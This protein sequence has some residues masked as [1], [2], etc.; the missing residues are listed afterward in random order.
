MDQLTRVK[1]AVAAAEYGGGNSRVS[2]LARRSGI[3]CL[4]DIFESLSAGD[5]DHVNAR[6]TALVSKGVSAALLG[7]TE[8]PQSLLAI[9]GSPPFL[10][11]MG[12]DALLSCPG[13]GVCGSRDVSSEGLRAAKACGE[14]ASQ[15]GFTVISGYARGVDITTHTSALSSGGTTVLVLPEGIE[16]FRVRRGDF[17]EVWDP[18]RTLVISQFAPGRPWSAGNA[19]AR[20]RVIIGL[21]LALIVVEARDRGGTLAAG[22]EALKLHRR[23]MALEFS[24]I[25][26][27]NAVLLERGAVSVRNRIELSERLL[28]LLDSPDYECQAMR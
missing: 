4:S 21:S 3:S 16:H 23:V 25:P 13:I 2:Q 19:M 6:A 15:Y 12:T 24:E 7:T 17:A 1:L 20:N 27:G 5:R 10:F 22:S 9:P 28:E 11:Y 18:K 8:Y 26:R 14:I